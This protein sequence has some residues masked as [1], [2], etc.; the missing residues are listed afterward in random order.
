MFANVFE[1]FDV[2]VVRSRGVVVFAVF[3]GCLYL[4]CCDELSVLVVVCVL[5]SW[6]CLFVVLVL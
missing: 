6:F 2:D 3:D 1:V 5:S 4:F